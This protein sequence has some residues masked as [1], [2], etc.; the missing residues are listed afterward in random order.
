M[1]L[2]SQCSP[3]GPASL[4]PSPPSF[5]QLVCHLEHIVYTLFQTWQKLCAYYHMGEGG[6][7][8]SQ[9]VRMFVYSDILL[10]QS[11]AAYLT[12][13]FRSI[14]TYYAVSTLMCL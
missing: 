10:E 7:T 8:E 2:S 1:F 4:A 9:D 11:A 14:S 13:S 6:R 12:P 5:A 3:S